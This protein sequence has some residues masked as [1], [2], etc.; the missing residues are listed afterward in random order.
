MDLPQDFGVP[1]PSGG[2]EDEDPLEVDDTP[3]FHKDYL[4]DV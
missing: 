2:G 4:A 3:E 1:D